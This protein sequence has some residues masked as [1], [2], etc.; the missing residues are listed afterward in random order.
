GEEREER[1]PDLELLHRRKLVLG[2]SWWRLRRL[3]G[4]WACQNRPRADHRAPQRVHGPWARARFRV[5]CVTVVAP[6][7]RGTHPEKG[8]TRNL[9]GAR[10]WPRGDGGRLRDDRAPNVTRMGIRVT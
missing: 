6:V 7:P 8:H 1:A 5:R 10:V 3:E 4:Q 9:L 2:E